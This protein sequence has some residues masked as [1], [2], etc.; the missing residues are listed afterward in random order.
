MPAFERLSK[1][2]TELYKEHVRTVL[3]NDEI[4][5]LEESCY[6]HSFSITGFE[7]NEIDC[8][9]HYESRMYNIFGLGWSHCTLRTLFDPFS[10]EYTET[11]M[12]EKLSIINRIIHAG[13]DLG[14]L[15]NEYMLRYYAQ[16]RNDIS[17]SAVIG[18]AN[19]LNKTLK[20]T[21]SPME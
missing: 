13:E 19:L 6:D 8:S 20:H 12:T 2:F 11:S 16:G 5:K 3:N 21:S 10:S 15:I 9:N 1:Y 17:S 18:V 4:E 7:R 14:G